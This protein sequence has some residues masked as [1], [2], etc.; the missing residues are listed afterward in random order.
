MSTTEPGGRFPSRA[1]LIL[2]AVAAAAQQPVRPQR[3]EPI[4][5]YIRQ[6]WTV[7]TRSNRTLAK[8][9]VDPK[10]HPTA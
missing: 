8:A 6:T 3:P 2:L 5:D 9:A 1:F 7:L 10:F 4:L